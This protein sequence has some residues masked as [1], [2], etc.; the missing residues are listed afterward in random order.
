[1][2]M[3]QRKKGSNNM[4]STLC[5]LCSEFC[6]ISKSLALCKFPR[7]L[8]S[9]KKKGSNNMVSTLCSLF[10]RGLFSYKKKGLKGESS[11]VVHTI[12]IAASITFILV[13]VATFVSIKETHQELI[14]K[15]EI[16]ELCL[17]TKDGIDKVYHQTRY[18]PITNTTL[19]RLVLSYPDRVAELNYRINFTG[20]TLYVKAGDYADSCTVGLNITLKGD[21]SGSLAEIIF[22]KYSNGTQE[23][24]M[25]NI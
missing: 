16:R 21:I 18:N 5:S 2:I 15:N 4:V 3:R 8:F 14:A 10:P 9:Y 23:V 24:E 17:L 25:R 1:M 11:F 20:N 22:R 6:G 12:L 19:G 7:G 13:V